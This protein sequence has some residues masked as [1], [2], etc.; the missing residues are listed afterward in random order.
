MRSILAD[1]QTLFF[2]NS[3]NIQQRV[4]AAK[5]LTAVEVEVK[6]MIAALGR[7][8]ERGEDQAIHYM[9][10]GCSVNEVTLNGLSDNEDWKIW[11]VT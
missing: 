10:S 1:D 9:I 4:Y 6:A 5:G 8:K 7:V 3:R 2:F 11:V